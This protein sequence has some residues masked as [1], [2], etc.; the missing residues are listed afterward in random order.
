MMVERKYID[1]W[2]DRNGPDGLVK[3]AQLAR[4][5]SS[6]MSKVRN[7]QVPKLAATR[8]RI[9]KALKLKEEDL[10]PVVEHGEEAS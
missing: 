3:L 10:F 2:V 5:S 1:T 6:L 7:G 4:V 9:S 8:L